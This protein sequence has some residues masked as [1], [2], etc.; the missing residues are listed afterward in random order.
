M[1]RAG[2]K[3]ETV[4]VVEERATVVKRDH[5]T[6]IVRLKKRIHE[7]EG[8]VDE[9]LRS[10]EYEI[11]RVSCDRWVDAAVPVRT[12]G[13]TTIYPV[14]REVIEKRLKLIEEVHVTRHDTIRDSRE[15]V[16]LKREEITVEKERR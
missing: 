16:T 11:R 12:E 1:T 4:P 15:P 2:K 8:S 5:T 7:E 14:L 9:R 10:I 6:A 3:T 13:A